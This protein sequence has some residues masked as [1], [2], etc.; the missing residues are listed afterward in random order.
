MADAV[1]VAIVGPESCGKSTLAGFLLSRLQSCGMRALL[2][3]EY[4]RAYYAERPYQPTPQ[5]VLE[6]A[7][8]QLAAEQAALLQKPD[9]ILCDSTV[10]T[11]K[12]WAEVAFGRGDQA[13]LDLYRPHDYAL[14]LL[15]RADIPWVADP[16]RSHENGRDALFDRYRAALEQDAV[17]W[18]EIHG[19]REYRQQLAWQGLSNVLPELSKN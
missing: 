5:A 12:I 6:I 15:T 7:R 17:A 18:M 3:E 19:Q 16:L 11:C 13:L 9:V 1:L 10:L 14:T 8:G 2:V 4:A